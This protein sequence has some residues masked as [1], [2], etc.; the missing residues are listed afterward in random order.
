MLACKAGA[1]QQTIDKKG[2]TFKGKHTQAYFALLKLQRK[3]I[4]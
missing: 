4:I 3:V 2:K 1:Y